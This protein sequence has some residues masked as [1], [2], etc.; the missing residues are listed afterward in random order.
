MHFMF[1]AVNHGLLERSV[2][3]VP[4]HSVLEDNR[5][6][7]SDVN[8][9]GPTPSSVDVALAEMLDSLGLTQLVGSPMCDSNLLDIWATTSSTLITNVAVNDAALIS[10]RRIVTANV[11]VR[12]PK[13]TV[14][15]TWRQLRKVDLSTFESA[16]RQSELFTSPAIGTD[17]YAEQLVR[18]VSQQLDVMAPLRHGLRRPAKP[19]TKWL[20]PDA[21]AAKRVRRRLERKWHSTGSEQDWR[22]YRHACQMANEL[23]VI[24][25]TVL[26]DETVFLRTS[27]VHQT[28]ADC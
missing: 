8:C 24:Q 22:A 12:S 3:D 6:V 28:L 17:D 5:V 16:I 7:C 18:V 23:I 1:F 20:S 27:V 13:P 21:V 11:T 2:K 10:D 15:Y 25:A 14:A 19:I 26:P 4:D 9:P